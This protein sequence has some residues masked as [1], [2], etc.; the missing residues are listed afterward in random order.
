MKNKTQKAWWLAAA[1]AG[2][3]LGAGL[4]KKRQNPYNFAGKVVLITGGSRGLGLVLARQFAAEGARL[5]ICARNLGELEAA[6]QEL[7]KNG[8]E[9]YAQVCNL[10]IEQDLKHMVRQV[11][12]YF[13]R[14]DVLINNAGVIQVG[15]LENQSVDEF[16]EALDIHYWAPLHTMMAVFPGMKARRE[17]RIINIASV[18]GK[19]SLPHMVP[20]SG[21]KFGLVGLSEGFQ[22]ELKKYGIL[23]TTIN[24]GLMRTGSASH[25]IIKGQ[26]EKE[27]AWFTATDVFPLISMSADV[28]ARK[29]I[30]ASRFGVPERTLTVAGKLAVV[31][32]GIAPSLM[33]DYFDLVNRFL[34]EPGS[35]VP[36]SGKSSD[37]IL[38]PEWA[39]KI[40]E[41]VAREHNE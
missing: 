20:Y 37:S 25:A 17:G 4:L 9:V 29:I 26:Q 22:I 18:G 12:E 33:A 36:A 1:A 8:V 14:I 2:A 15:P 32:H 23:V 40:N 6:Q 7:E 38:T 11:E 28:A 21:S 34:P 39:R 19:V 16:R 10:R 5:A 27:Y 3:L 24:P 41:S 30:K 13:G 31:L 35:D